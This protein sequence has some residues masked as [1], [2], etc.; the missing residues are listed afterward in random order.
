MT[1]IYGASDDLIEIDGDVSEE[2]NAYSSDEDAEWR[3]A[4]SDGTLL[5]VRYDGCWRFNQLIAGSVS[6]TRVEADAED[7][8]GSRPD[9]GPWYSD[10]L[11]FADGITWVALSKASDV[12]T[13]Q[14]LRKARR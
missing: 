8:P 4:L 2:F 1:K 10:V 13:K 9:G 14:R 6:F 12:A 5:S 11:T 7:K 3:L